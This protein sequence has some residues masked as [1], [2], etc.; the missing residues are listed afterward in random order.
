MLSGCGTI[1]PMNSVQQFIAEYILVP[2]AH[3]LAPEVSELLKRINDQVLNPLIVLMFTAALVLF[4]FGL[5][6]FFGPAGKQGSESINDGKRH[7]LWGIVGMAIMVSVFG[8]MNFIT[9]TL[10]VSE[11]NPDATTDFSG[12]T[13]TQ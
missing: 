8:I 9:S 3:A 13:N 4:V 11:V 6:K 1:K 7:L 2:Q 5:Y 10:G 12:L